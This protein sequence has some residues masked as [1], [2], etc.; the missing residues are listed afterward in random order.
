MLTGRPSSSSTCIDASPV[1]ASRPIMLRANAAS[2]FPAL[3]FQN[4]ELLEGALHLRRLAQHARL[5]RAFLAKTTT[6]LTQFLAA[7]ARQRCLPIT[8]SITLGGKA[9]ALHG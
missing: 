4:Q 7:G 2:S 1:S 5:Q 8:F 3:R 9:R 6:E